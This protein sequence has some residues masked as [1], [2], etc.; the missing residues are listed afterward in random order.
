MWEQI[1]SKKTMTSKHFCLKWT[2]FQSNILSAFESLQNTEDLADVTLTCDGINIKAHKFILSACS[3]Y[4]RTIFKENPCPHPIVILKD[5]SICR[6][7]GHN[8]FHVPWRSD[9]N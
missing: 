6:P 8:K 9:S 3:P 7:Y 5:V 2:R 1:P 4:F